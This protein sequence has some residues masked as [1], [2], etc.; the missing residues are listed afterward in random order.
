MAPTLNYSLAPVTSLSGIALLAL[1]SVVLL[2][3]I[4][5]VFYSVPYPKGMALVGEPAGATRFSLRTYWRYYTDCR[6]LFREAYDNY[7][8]KGK[9]VV[10]PGLG[11]RHEVIMPT[12][13]MRWVQTYPETALDQGKAFVEVDQVYWALGDGR[14]VDDGWHGVL[15]RTELNAALE[16]ICASLNDEL[17]IAF[18]KWFGTDPEWKGMNLFESV[19]MVVAQAASRFTI[20]PGICRNEEY[21]NLSFD[22]VN[23][24]IMNAGATGGSPRVLRPVVGTLVNLT[25]HG[26]INR[27]KAMFRPIWEE[28]VEI[29]RRDRD[30]PD[31]VE[32]PQDHLQ[33]M[34]RYAKEHRPEEFNDLD[35]MTRRLI[36]ANFGSMHQTSIQVTN[37]L[38]NILASDAEFDTIAV[39]RDEVDRVLRDDDNDD[40]DGNWTKAKVSRMVKADSVAR[41]T[42]R[43]HSFGGRAV[44]RKVMVDGLETPDG[45]V[46]PRGTI[47]SF[48]AHPAQTDGEAMKDPLKYDPFR[49]SRIREAAARDEKPPA[50]SFVTTGPEY[51]PFGHGKHACPGR[52]LIDFELKMIIAYLLGHYDVELPAEYNGKR[53]ENYWLTEACFPPD[54]VRVRIRRKKNADGN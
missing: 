48:L 15:V 38:L 32:E 50:V 7:S 42:L 12:N 10:I 49:F 44:F 8:K 54:G 16:N 9:P 1:G 27:L 45:H 31:H 30:G 20:G 18:D 6:G 43:L 25:L 5:R 2:Y 4:S 51:L 41:E 24:L 34:A 40:N 11:F 35:I 19:K 37:M 26:K 23:R 52:F 14:Y 29:L 33:M 17:G 53:P 13:S 3:L 46:L 47:I 39:L 21:L 22:I 28:R 36:A